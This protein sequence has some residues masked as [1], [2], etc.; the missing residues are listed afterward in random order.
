MEEILLP[1]TIE[2]KEGEQIN[3]GKVIITPCHQG[4]GTTL[5]NALRRVLLSSLPGAAVEAVRINGVAHEFSAIP[6]VK[7]DMIEIILN[8]KQLAVRCFSDQ[9]VTLS[10]RKK[11]KGII[12][13]ADFGKNADVEIVNPDLKLFTITTDNTK[14]EMEIIIGLGRG[15]KP[16]EEKSSKSLD[17]G[18][19]LIDSLYTPIRDIGYNVESTR[20]GDVIDYEKLTLHIETNGTITPREAVQQATKILMD[21]FAL[22]LEGSDADKN[23]EVKADS[24]SDVSEEETIVKKTRPSSKARAEGKKTAK[25]R[26]LKKNNYAP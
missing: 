2:F 14:I 10:L 5:G 13:A 3:V 15:F 24:V 6:G 26:A 11:G 23:E 19:I 25:K 21:H 12:T 1:T 22:I 20:V 9:A 18:T 7:E 8:L 4:Y 17:L 16:V